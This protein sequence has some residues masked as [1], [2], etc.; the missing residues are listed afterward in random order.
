MSV[1][2]IRLFPWS[3]LSSDGGVR[4]LKIWTIE[5]VIFWPP[6]FV[7]SCLFLRNEMN[8]PPSN[9]TGITVCVCKHYTKP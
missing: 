8:N 6:F 3:V 7:R 1:K 4:T 9:L 5:N 2:K